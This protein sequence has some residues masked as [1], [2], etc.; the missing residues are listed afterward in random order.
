[1]SINADQKWNFYYPPPYTMCAFGD[2]HY[3]IRWAWSRENLGPTYGKDKNPFGIELL[4]ASHMVRAEIWTERSDSGEILRLS[5][6][7]S[8]FIYALE[9]NIRRVESFIWKNSAFFVEKAFISVRHL[10][11]FPK[12]RTVRFSTTWWR[13]FWV[14]VAWRGTLCLKRSQR[15]C[16]C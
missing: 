12:F 13:Y 4:P 2:K 14:T 7:R 10:L 1:M 15:T 6:G 3:R 8:S 9:S 11:A 16:S 5:V